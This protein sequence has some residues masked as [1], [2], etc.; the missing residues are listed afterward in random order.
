MA[1][2]VLLNGEE[3][4]AEV[5]LF[6]DAT[7]FQTYEAWASEL[8]V[9]STDVR[10]SF[11]GEDENL[12]NDYAFPFPLASPFFDNGGTYASYSTEAA[13][14]LYQ[15]TPSN[16]S[17][18]N[19]V[20]PNIER[21][22]GLGT[23]PNL[24]L[25]YHPGVTVASTP[26]DYGLRYQSAGDVAIIYAIHA[27]LSGQP[28]FYYYAAIRIGPGQI[29]FIGQASGNPVKIYLTE[30]V[31]VQLDEVRQQV[32]LFEQAPN[33]TIHLSLATVVPAI[34]AWAAAPTLLG[35]PQALVGF[36]F[37]RQVLASAPAVLGH[38]AVLARQPAH[39]RVAAPSLLRHPQTLALVYP[40][41]RAVAAG[42]LRIPGALMYHDFTARLGDAVTHYVMDLVTPTGRVRVPISSWQATLQTGSS[43]YV[44]CV[45]PACGM[46]RP[47]LEAATEFAIYRRA[48]VPGV[49][50]IEY[51]MARAP[52]EQVQYDRGPTNYTCTLSGY[53]PAFADSIDPPPVVYD[54]TLS[55]VRSISSSG[56][57]G[58]VR[59]R[60]AVDWLLRPGHRA[61][62]D[63]VPFVVAFI[64]Y[65]SPSGFDSY[66][67]VGS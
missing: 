4:S 3:I 59:V 61:F 9:S 47:A 40:V 63:G 46:W 24:L 49:A 48:V 60:C 25:S 35:E 57:L 41:G 23:R 44:Q 28:D 45:I 65:Y 38:A 6:S 10:P 31:E 43:N 51:E 67:D 54:R 53:S 16:T 20:I 7:P 11:L 58:R 15:S 8:G 64:N 66:M 39:G 62:V 2:I 14:G 18:T 12:T 34:K 36:D 42:P 1:E 55:G 56:P 32:L 37:Y 29:D 27:T 22:F 13:L 21:T 26:L 19:Y 17:S 30:M 5:S 52:T 33:T 50:A